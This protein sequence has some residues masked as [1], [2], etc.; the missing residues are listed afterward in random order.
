[1]GNERVGEERGRCTGKEDKEEH[2]ERGEA[3]K[4][5]RDK[6]RGGEKKRN[7]EIEK[8]KKCKIVK[9]YWK[10]HTHTGEVASESK[11][12]GDKQRIKKTRQKKHRRIRKRQKQTKTREKEVK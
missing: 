4:K 12:A 5:G 9:L 6:E 8:R 7:E 1:M 2:Y 3:A 11:N 10:N